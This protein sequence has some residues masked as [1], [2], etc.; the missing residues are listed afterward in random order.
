MQVHNWKGGET[1]LAYNCFNG[2]CDVGLG[3]CPG[4]NPD[5]TFASNGGQYRARRLTVLVK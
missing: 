4:K 3:N 2:G 1:V 5:W